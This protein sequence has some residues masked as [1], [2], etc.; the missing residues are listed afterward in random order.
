MRH[1]RPNQQR[2]NWYCVFFFVS[3]FVFLGVGERGRN[4]LAGMRLLPPAGYAVV[5]ALL[6][7]PL[8]SDLLRSLL[9]VSPSF[10]LSPFSR[11]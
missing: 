10:P 1:P 3:F 8:P 11:G 7:C 5:G 4:P 9:V 2:P 6:R